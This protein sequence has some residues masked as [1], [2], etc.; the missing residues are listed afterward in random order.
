MTLSTPADD[1]SLAGL[2]PAVEDA[3]GRFLDVVPGDVEIAD[4]LPLRLFTAAPDGGES[5]F[6]DTGWLH[7]QIFADGAARFFARVEG[8]PSQG[9]QVMQLYES[10]VAGL[11]DAAIER[12]YA[13]ASPDGSS[14]VVLDDPSRYFTALLVMRTGRE[15]VIPVRSAAPELM[16]EDGSLTLDALARRI[17]ATRPFGVTPS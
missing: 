7:V 13:L 12:A 3:L 5:A 11:I 9:W 1:P 14:L 10:P 4:I 17:A 16:V 6:V 15:V 8:S 2:A